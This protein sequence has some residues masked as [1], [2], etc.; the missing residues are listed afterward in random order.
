MATTTARGSQGE[1]VILG[2]EGDDQVFGAGRFDPAAMP[3]LD[4]SAL[5]QADLA[6]LIFGG[7]GNDEIF[8]EGGND[9]IIGGDGDDRL[10]GRWGDDV[11]LGGAGDD[12]MGG[13]VGADT[14]TGGEGSDLSVL[15]SAP[16][17]T[18]SARSR[19]RSARIPRRP[20]ATRR[21]H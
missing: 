9:T 13:G 20:R 19:H 7:A 12:R 15:A 6:D 11:I 8:G 1:D 3:G 10:F 5:A 16:R 4:P 14:V 2:G 18:C 21:D 17:H